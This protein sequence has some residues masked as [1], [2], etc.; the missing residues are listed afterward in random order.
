M[1]ANGFFC[2]SHHDALISE[3]F[4]TSSGDTDELKRSIERVLEA[5]WVSGLIEVSRFIAGMNRMLFLVC[6]TG[7]DE[8]EKAQFYYAAQK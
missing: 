6:V 4:E 3:N 7:C 1:L 2:G 5:A 8:A